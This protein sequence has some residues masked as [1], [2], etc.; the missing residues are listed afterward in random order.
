MDGPAPRAHR[1]EMTICMLNTFRYRRGGDSAYALGLE[2]LLAER[3]HAVL[4][5]AMHHPEELPTEHSRN[6]APEIDYPALM[7]QGGLRSALTVLSNSIYNRSAR[8][9]LARFFDEYPIDLVHA[10]SVMHHLTAAVI[11]ECYARSIPVVWTLHDLKSVCPTA[12][13]Q[14]DGQVC[15][16][17]S[18]GRFYNALRH[19]CKRGSLGAS[20]VVTAELYLHRLWNI[21]EKADLLIAPSQFLRDKLIESGLK[22]KR[23]EVLH[24]HVNTEGIEVP[25]EAGSYVLYVGRLSR[26]KGVATLMEACIR[27]GVRLRI[28]GTGELRED[29]QAQVVVESLVSL[30]GHVTGAALAD[31]YRGAALVAVPSECQE[32]CPLVALEAY[33]WGKPVLGSRL[34][35]LVELIDDH[36]VGELLEP[37]NVDDWSSSL[38]RWMADPAGRLEA[39]RRARERA[40]IHFSPQDHVD[41]IERFYG[42]VA[43]VTRS[44]S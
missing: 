40:E 17:C 22:P 16:E 19:R 8:A 25:R 5:F 3:G 7:N 20:A 24:N 31:L 36:G 11:Q 33:A 10:H 37:G 1:H 32:N 21:Y 18:G 9:S 15:E 44:T 27:A 28:A 30:E 23:I 26:E 38:S 12:L 2:S 41:Q 42:E 14:R 34:G 6:F 29:L 4:P 43:G 39:G 35:G 13:Y